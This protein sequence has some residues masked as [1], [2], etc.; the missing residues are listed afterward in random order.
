MRWTRGDRGNIEDRR[1][2]SARMGAMPLGIGGILV[3]LVLSWFTGVDFLSLAG[4]LPQE[5]VETTTGGPIE[6]TPRRP[7]RS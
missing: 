2:S 4:G 5:Q 1:G 3:L 7:G 6:T